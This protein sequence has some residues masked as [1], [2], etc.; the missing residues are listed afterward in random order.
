MGPWSTPTIVAYTY[1][2]KIAAAKKALTFWHREALAY[3]DN[4]DWS[5]DKLISWMHE[6]NKVFLENFGYSV[7][8]TVDTR[9]WPIVQE[10]MEFI[11][12]EASG[13]LPTFSDGFFQS[14]DFMNVLTDAVSTYD[15]TRVKKVASEV[16]ADTAQAGAILAGV[17]IGGAVTWYLIAGG[18]TLF[19]LAMN[20]R[21]K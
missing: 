10:K 16:A 21:K 14:Q 13:R 7:L 4:Y 15:W 3:P 20:A 19:I 1:E 11:A 12:N 5:F 6:S 17:A 18:F 9:G 8:L 2:Q